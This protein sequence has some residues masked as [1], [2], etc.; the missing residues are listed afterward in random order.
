MTCQECK[1][2]C[3]KHLTALTGEWP[4][5]HLPWAKMRG[6]VKQKDADLWEWHVRSPCQHLSKT[7]RC[8]IYDNRPQVCREFEVGGKACLKAQK[9]QKELEAML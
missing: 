9:I 5:E 3:C 1:A 6:L 4:Q 2:A 8:K 7:G